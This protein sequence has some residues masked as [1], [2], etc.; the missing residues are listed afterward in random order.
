VLVA[1]FLQ[2]AYGTQVCPYLEKVFE[3]QGAALSRCSAQAVFQAMICWLREGAVPLR[4]PTKLEDEAEL[5][6]DLLSVVGGTDFT[7][8]FLRIGGQAKLRKVTEYLTV[9]KTFQIKH[10]IDRSAH[11]IAVV[12]GDLNERQYRIKVNPNLNN[13]PN[14]D[15]KK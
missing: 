1:L 2:G 10:G 8:V 15:Q 5:P 14:E 13:I 12:L 4:C 7:D 6:F 9:F 3:V 11:P